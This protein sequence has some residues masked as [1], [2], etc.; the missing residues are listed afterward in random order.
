MGI[1]PLVLSEGSIRWSV[2]V[3]TFVSVGNATQPFRRLIDKTVALAPRLPRPVVVQQGNTSLKGEGYIA[4][5][6]MGMEEFGQCMAHAELLILHAGAG[7]VIHAIQA[8]KIPVVM[9]RL[10]KYRESIDD[11]QLEFARALAESGKIVLVEDPADLMSAVAEALRRQQM[12]PAMKEMPRMASLI[13]ALLRECVQ[14]L[15]R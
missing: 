9:P 4:Q 5:S 2:G 13:G 11:H 1:P 14:G 6:F 8:G 12:A 10:V 7:S 3:M 15:N